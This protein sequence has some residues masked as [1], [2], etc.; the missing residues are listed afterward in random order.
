MNSVDV[1]RELREQAMQLAIILMPD[2][3]RESLQTILA[4]LNEFASFSSENQVFIIFIHL[5]FVL[6]LM[7]NL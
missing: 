6:I 1:P 2:E 7:F 4:F 3:N 5:T